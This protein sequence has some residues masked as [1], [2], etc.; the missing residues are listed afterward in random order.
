MTDIETVLRNYLLGDTSITDIV[1]TR[2][3]C[4]R[5]IQDGA[6]PYIRFFKI[7][8]GNQKENIGDDGS[9]PTFQIDIVSDTKKDI[10]D[11]DD[12]VR[13]RLAYRGIG[14]EITQDSVYIYFIFPGNSRD[15][16]GIDNY[17]HRAVDYLIKYMRD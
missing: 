1:S 7:S 16:D 12:A 14:H 2:I 3:Y 13:A 5:G 6:M 8:D 17:Y 4:S 9:S 11:I 15:L 10:I